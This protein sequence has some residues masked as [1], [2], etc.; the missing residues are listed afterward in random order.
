MKRA[1]ERA[2]E[3]SIFKWNAIALGCASDNGADNCALC[4]HFYDGCEIIGDGDCPVYQKTGLTGCQATPFE[5]WHAVM[6]L[7]GL[8]IEDNKRNLPYIQTHH[9]VHIDSACLFAER[10]VEFLV[11]LLPDGHPIRKELEFNYPW[12]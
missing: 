4:W 12:P 5:D 9:S 3:K 11:S 6:S 7:H 10:E 1:L 2:I 8:Q